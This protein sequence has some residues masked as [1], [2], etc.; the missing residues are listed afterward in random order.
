MLIYIY[1]YDMIDM[2]INKITFVIAKML[3]ETNY[4][5]CSRSSQMNKTENTFL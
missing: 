1:I 5:T 2:S 4:Y 3:P